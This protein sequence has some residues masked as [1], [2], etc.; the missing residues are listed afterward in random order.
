MARPQ[1]QVL[2]AVIGPDEVAVMDGF[3]L[4]QRSAQHL[5]HDQDML[6][7]PAFPRLG[8]GMALGSLDPHIAFGVDP[9]PPTLAERRQRLAFALLCPMATAQ[10]IRKVSVVT[11][12]KLT[13]RTVPLDGLQRLASGE[14]VKMARA[15][16]VGL[17]FAVA[18]RKATWLLGGAHGE[19]SAT[20][21]VFEQGSGPCI[22]FTPIT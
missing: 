7:D 12:G 17:G 11:A 4:S 10:S 13:T 20:E 9:A 3:A 5:R 21:H 6:G 19:Y 1:L 18:V 2:G 15:K 8:V 22:T 16:P 14:L